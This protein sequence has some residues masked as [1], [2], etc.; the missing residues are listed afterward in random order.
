[1]AVVKYW[2]RRP[3]RDDQVHD[4]LNGFDS[5]YRNPVFDKLTG[6][7]YTEYIV[8]ERVK[9]NYPNLEI[10]F[11]AE[12]MIHSNTLVKCALYAKE[13]PP[14]QAKHFLCSFNRSFHRSR[15]LLVNRLKEENWFDTNYCSCG[16]AEDVK[17]GFD[18]PNNWLSVNKEVQRNYAALNPIIQD[19]FVQIVGETVGESYVP[20]PTEKCMYPIA[21][22]TL[23]VAYAQPGWYAWVEKHWGFQKF[24]CFDY[25][26]DSVLDPQKR[27]DTLIEM[28]RPF[29]HRDWAAIYKQQQHTLDYNFELLKSRTFIKNLRK[30][31]QVDRDKS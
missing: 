28:L 21:N 8:D 31:D 1:M 27:L 12:L 11:D 20:F 4:H 18:E 2:S 15:Y 6:T 7:I 19:C 3:F 14:K 22:K 30:F 29:Q 13:P 5:N 23:W 16:F 25:S 26:F 10:K 17:I 24:D 9:N